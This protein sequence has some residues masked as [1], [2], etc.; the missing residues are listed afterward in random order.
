M[1]TIAVCT[2]WFGDAGPTVTLTMLRM[3][4]ALRSFAIA[5]TFA[6]SAPVSFPPSAR[7]NTM[8]AA[9]LVTWPLCGNALSCRF[10]ARID[11]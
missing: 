5:V 8:M 2:R 6:E 1:A 9:A 11:S 3:C 7:E 10:I 4:L